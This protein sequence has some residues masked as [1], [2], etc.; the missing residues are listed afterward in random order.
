MATNNPELKIIIDAQNDSKK[1]FAEVSKNLDNLSKEAQKSSKSFSGL[2]GGIGTALKA[3]AG[4]FAIREVFNFLKS[5]VIDFQNEEKAIARLTAVMTNVNNATKQEIDLLKEQA[6]ALQQLTNFGD[7]Q[8]I[9]AQA[10]LGTFQLNSAQ[11]QEITPRILDMG[12]AMEK[13]SGAGTDLESITI[14]VGKAMTSGIGSLSRYGVVIT[15]AQ[16][17][18]FELATQEEKVIILTEALDANFK[19]IAEGSAQT[20]AGGITKL[21]NNFGDFKES[22]GKAVSVLTKDLVWAFGV[23]IGAMNESQARSN[24]LIIGVNK[25]KEAWYSLGATIVMVGQSIKIASASFN[26]FFDKLLGGNGEYFQK[27]ID[28]AKGKIGETVDTMGDM[29]SEIDNMNQGLKDGT[30]DWDAYLGKIND[31]GAGVKNFNDAASLNE[32]ELKKQKDAIDDVTNKLKDYKKGINDIQKAQEEESIS[33]IK[34]QI[35]KKQSFEQQLADMIADHKEKWMKANA[36]R[37]KI[38]REG[39]K[40]SEDLNKVGELSQTAEREFNIIQPYLN[41]E[42]LSKLSQTSDVERMINAYRSTQAADT[43]ATAIKQQELKNK[44]QEMTINFDLRGATITDKDFIQKVKDELNKSLN[45][46]RFTN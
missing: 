41:N 10:M 38:E 16:K 42:N 39:I 4:F 34:S 5:S 30:F 44:A 43:E 45:L 33:F 15:D 6:A 9:S 46:I 25:L 35:E 36:D 13:S 1:A 22:V 19:G 24:T 18:S 40:N 17:K 21:K 29:Q 12:A 28:E 23:N 31:A 2:A 7:E 8:V 11:I 20:F 27:Q 3:F 37:E 32:E 14:A 26:K